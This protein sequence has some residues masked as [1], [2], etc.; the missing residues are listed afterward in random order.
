MRWEGVGSEG[1]RHERGCTN[2]EGASLRNLSPTAD[3]TSL[4]NDSWIR[5]M[6]REHR[7]IEPFTDTLVRHDARGHKVI[8]YGLSSY[9]YDLSLAPEFMVFKNSHPVLV[10]PK[11]FDERCVDHVHGEQIIIPPNS[12]VLARSNESIRMPENVLGI[13]V[14]KSS[15]ARCGLILN[16][17]PLEPGWS[18]HLTLE[19]TNSTPLPSVCYANEGIVQVIFFEGE[20]CEVS[21]A[22][23]A[24]KYQGQHGITLPRV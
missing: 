10:D 22:D 12:F 21:Y 14:G 8:S 13:C 11:K 19:I 24:G 6:A 4:K 7:M 17:T 2:T 23:R 3:M 5:Q 15:Y 16:C 20:P 9:G 1:G 18:G